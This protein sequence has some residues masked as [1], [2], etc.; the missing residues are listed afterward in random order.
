MQIIRCY[1]CSTMKP[2]SSLHNIKTSN[3][4]PSTKFYSHY[5]WNKFYCCNIYFY[6]F[7]FFCN[8][9]IYATIKKKLVTGSLISKCIKHTYKKKKK[10][11]NY[12]IQ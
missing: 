11:K 4:L 3:P 1:I 10:K 9:L 12:T 5:W 7:F 2:G 6:L 8:F